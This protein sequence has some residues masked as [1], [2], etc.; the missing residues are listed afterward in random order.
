MTRTAQG[1]LII[2]AI[3]ASVWAINKYGPD[4]PA[5]PP[6]PSATETAASTHPPK[7][8]SAATHPASVTHSAPAAQTNTSVDN[9][10]RLCGAF[11]QM[12]LLSDKCSV[13]GWSSAVDIS[14]DTTA[15]EAHKIC[16]ISVN[17]A[18]EHGINFDAGWQLRIYS[19]FSNGNTLAVCSLT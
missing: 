2:G 1:W 18:R 6:S 14:V 5:A 9:A 19:P 10:F 15:I 12:G 16:A 3:A 8:A 4:L 7:P 11:D 17:F 13:S